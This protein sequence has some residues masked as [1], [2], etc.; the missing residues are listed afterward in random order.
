MTS[1][2]FARRLGVSQST[3]S[4]ALNDSPLVSDERKAYI[5]QMAQELGFQLNSQAQSLKT[6]RTGT[7]GI[8]FPKHFKS[9]NDN[10]MMARFYDHIQREMIKHDYDVMT[11]YDF[12][13]EDGISV[14]ERI[15][16]RRKVDGLITL[17]IELSS[18]ER[19]LIRENR[20]PC[21]SLLASSSISDE[22][23]Y[24]LCDSEEAGFLAGTLFGGQREYRPVYLS[25]EEE[26][27]D[28]AKR[29]RG[30]RR[31]L[32]E[33]GRE[34]EDGDVFYCNLSYVSAYEFAVRNIKLFRREK[35]A[36]FAYSDTLALGLLTALREHRVRV[37]DQTQIIGMDGLPL[38]GWVRP[39]LSTLDVPVEEMVERG[40][41]TLVN[42]IEGRAA[43]RLKKIHK[44]ILVLRD[45]TVNPE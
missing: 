32:A 10:M 13:R 40:C 33:S 29:L 11:I 21:L 38:T 18:R 39:R 2:E 28:S 22:L 5:L 3:V 25:V 36:V 26:T 41:Q 4:R 45:T 37:P 42:L 15:A 34:L 43:G 23:H 44:P 14:F 6:N 9:M 35:V 30:F 12:G 8:L 24:C 27:D 19:E 31:G 16:R 1:K 20:F 17:R 7:V